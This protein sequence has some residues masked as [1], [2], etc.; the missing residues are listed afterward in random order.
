MFF[1]KHGVQAV[2]EA[3]NTSR[4]WLIWSA[5][6]EKA[7]DNDVRLYLQFSS[8]QRLHA[9]VSANGGYFEHNNVII[10]DRY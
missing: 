6:P 9:C 3:R 5:L 8:A 2:I 4:V 10:H 1:L 7:I